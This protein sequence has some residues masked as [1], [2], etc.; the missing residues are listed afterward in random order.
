MVG[1]PMTATKHLI[2]IEAAQRTPAYSTFPVSEI[3]GGT[4][5]LDAEAYM[6]DGF[7]A[8]NEI[9]RSNLQVRPLGELA[10]I[11][12]PFPSRMKA[13]RVAPEHGVPFLTAT[14]VFDIWP[15][16]RKWIAPSKT[17]GLEDR[18]VSP[19][20]ILVTCSGA[21][22]DTIMAYSA[23]AGLVVSDDLLRVESH[24]NALQGYIYAFLRTR[25]GRAMMTAGQY[26]SIIKHLDISHLE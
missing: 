6:L 5:R 18:Y 12:R 9:R 8:R 21:V 3:I 14:Q 4:R 22:G 10:R 13:I 11:W 20:W 19:G 2:E 26:G 23:H 24:D 16:P 7:V 17:P 1:G 25:A 15:T